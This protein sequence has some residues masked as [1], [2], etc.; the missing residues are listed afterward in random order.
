MAITAMVMVKNTNNNRKIYHLNIIGLLYLMVVAPSLVFAG[1][2]TLI[3]NISLDETFTD[4]VELTPVETTSSFVTQTIAGLDA[5]YKSSLTTLHWSGTQIYALYSH[6]SE[7]ND[8]FR[9]LSANGQHSFWNGGPALTAS[10]SIANISQNNARNGQADIVSGGTVQ[11]NSYSTGLQYNFGN[12]SYSVTSSANY[13]ITR[14]EDS[15]GESNGF[16]AQLGSE[17]G[18]NAR[19]LYW[20][21]STG[22]TKR[23]QQSTDNNGEN[24]TVEALLGAITPWNLNPFIRYYDENVQGSGVNQNLNITSSWGPGIRWLATPHII[25]DLSY[26]FVADETA[27]DDYVDTS[28]QW[29]PSARTSLTLGFSQRFFGHAYNLNFSHQTRR[30]T[31]SISYDETLQVFDRNTYQDITPGVPELVES[32]EFSLNKRLAWSSQLQLSRTSFNV[33]ISANERTSLETDIVDD[34]FGTNIS[35]TRT[36]SAKSSLSLSAEFNYS[37]YDNDNPEGSRQ[38]DYYRSISANFTRNL[39]SSLSCYFTVE[40]I[41]RDSTIDSFS[42]DEVRA[43]INITKEF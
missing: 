4:N 3:P 22:Y 41:N 42:Y 28:I 24:Y 35:V 36:I 40:H 30:L 10:A 15:I 21:L 17:N 43:I 34:T 13:D 31:N 19:H 20:Q 37:I 23:M 18:N 6:D 16:T 1:D 9:T 25:I 33:T 39:A 8:H 7:L 11:Q 29:E 14:V 26:N 32:D 2:W 5:E 38:E 27:S 12:S